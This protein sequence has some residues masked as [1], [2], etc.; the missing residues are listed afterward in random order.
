MT[1]Q[2]IL[3]PIRFIG[4]STDTKPTSVAV[5]SIFYEWDTREEYICIDG[6]QWAFKSSA[7]IHHSV[8]TSIDLNQA[9][10]TYDLFTGTTA[11]IMIH[12]LSV[13]IPVD[14]TGSATLTSIS[15]VSNDVSPITF[16]STTTG[17]K[18]NLTA[19]KLLQ[20]DGND[21]VANTKDIQLV[22]AGGAAGV[23]CVAL[24]T[25]EY[26][27]TSSADGYLVVA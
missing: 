9:A 27:P 23:S 19:G 26:T 20:Y 13:Y 24:V 10:S 21:T 3:T 11:A 5:G 17:A 12:H 2:A 22:I 6:T 25:V 4:L 15:V 1:M 7:E 8:Y 16:I 18:A 14:I